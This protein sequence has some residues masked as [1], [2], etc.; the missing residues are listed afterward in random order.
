MAP[1]DNKQDTGQFNAWLSNLAKPAGGPAPARPPAPGGQ[2]PPQAAKPKP[3]G[4][5]VLGDVDGEVDDIFGRIVSEEAPQPFGGYTPPAAHAAA[6]PVAPPPVQPVQPQ[7]VYQQPQPAPAPMAAPRAEMPAFAPPPRPAA[8]PPVQPQ[9]YRPQPVVPAMPPISTFQ[10]SP[11]PQG[12]PAMDPRM[13]EAQI[14]GAVAEAVA[15]LQQQMEQMK[16]Q[17]QAEM[18]QQAAVLQGQMQSQYQANLQA[19]VSQAKM[20]VGAQVKDLQTKFQE[21]RQKWEKIL[22]DLR[23]RN[24]ELLKANQEMEQ[25]MASL[26]ERHSAMIQEYAD[27]KSQSEQAA[28]HAA[29]AQISIPDLKPEPSN[30]SEMAM[31]QAMLQPEPAEVS[32]PSELS[33]PQH[34]IQPEQANPMEAEIHPMPEVRIEMPSSELDI[35]GRIQPEAV[36][37]TPKAKEAHPDDNADLMAELEALELE[38]KKLKG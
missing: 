34:L 29:S 23:S 9:A 20:E 27:L 11:A 7:P 32:N 38:M 37:E 15:G 17:H 26:R 1:Q 8:P 16:A 3:Q 10:P 22:N 24:D 21:Q 19:A 13:I 4:G 28:Y 12:M 25:Q 31:P 6:A 35:P 33:L 36:L 5:G 14:E 2:V 18:Q 30:P